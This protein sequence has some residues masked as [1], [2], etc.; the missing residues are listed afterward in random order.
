MKTTLAN[1]KQ[2]M[3]IVLPKTLLDQITQLANED[4][5]SR[6][7]YV[8]RILEDHINRQKHND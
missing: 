6:S 1:D 5:R 2:Y 8:A 3:T 4:G 7:N